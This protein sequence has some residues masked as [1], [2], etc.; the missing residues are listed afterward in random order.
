MAELSEI[1]AGPWKPYQFDSMWSVLQR[2]IDIN[3][4]KT[5]LLA[6][7]QPAHHLQELVGLAASTSAPRKFARAVGQLASIN[8]VYSVLGLLGPAPPPVDCLSWTFAQMERA[9]ARL[10][11]ILDNHGI[12]PGATIVILVSSCAEWA[13]MIWV[14]ALKCYTLVT[15]DT[16]MLKPSQEEELK[17]LINKLAP[18]LIMVENETVALAIDRLRSTKNKQ[19]P[20]LGITLE[21]LTDTLPG[22]TSIIDIS[23]MSFANDLKAKPATDN[24]D[25]TAMIVFTSGTS[26]G[27]PK[28]CIRTVGNL[29]RMVQPLSIP[30]LRSPFALS[31][32]KNYLGCAPGLLFS[33]WYTGNTAVLAGG[34]FTPATTLSALDSCRPMALIVTE[35]ILMD[36]LARHSD[37]S[38]TRVSSMRFVQIIGTVTSIERLRRMRRVFSNAQ[39]AAVYGMTEAVGF[40]GW[41]GAVPKLDTIPTFQGVAS[42]GVALPGIKLKV[43]DDEGRIMRRN[44]PGVLHISGEVVAGGYWDG[45][46]AEAFYQE[47]GHRWYITGDCAVIDDDRHV[48][49]LGRN[50]HMIRNNGTIIAPATIEN[51]LIKDVASTA[52]V[53][54][55][56]TLAGKEVPYAIVDKD[57]RCLEDL[58]DI[59][60]KNLGHTHRLGGIVRLDQLGLAQWPFTM[61]G[62]LLVSDLRRKIIDYLESGEALT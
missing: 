23:T 44:E 19:R 33:S 60:V 6:P 46:R 51:V 52:V 16:T 28:G 15:L 56:K 54:G 41:T 1:D 49:I 43:V 9:A 13:L 21:P 39:I 38:E 40:V 18:L 35:P 37:Y 20:F 57:D 55:L 47:D 42:A 58:Q 7:S 31:I 3:P 25:R 62:K 61:S 53:V 22:W 12:F 14:A 24:L 2:G 27:R 29:L 45:E 36:I 8:T 17:S 10:G 4:D 59:V 48:Y 30:P 50:E 32:S 26:T 11:S 34:E 5:A